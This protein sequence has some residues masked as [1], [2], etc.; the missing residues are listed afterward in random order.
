MVKVSHELP[1]CLLELDEEINDYSFCLPHLM[2]ENPVYRDHFLKSKE[3]GRY[4]IMDN[5]L[6]ELGHAYDTKR[7]LHWIKILEPNEF[8]VPDVWEDKTQTL[9]KAKY[10]SQIELPK[11]V[12]KMVVVQATTLHEAFLCVQTFK[13]LG[14]KKIAFSYGASYYND[15]CKHPN[16]DL[17]KALGRLFVI[18]TLYSQGML[19][20]FDRVHLLGTSIPQEF[21]WYKGIECIESLDT[22]NPV[23]SALNGIPYTS[24]GLFE[25]PK[26]NLNNDF[27]ISI[28]KID[29][30]LIV[31]NCR[32]F[33]KINNL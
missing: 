6:H 17:G 3:K 5:S 1:L 11:G 7:L 18:S 2:D 21:G 9:V 13:D 22:S 31:E 32:M 29:F 28:D 16:K 20:K 8:V 12:E 33:R 23:M 26:A 30:S 25:K 4:I 19:T 10:W 14:Y 15:I 24:A 27:T